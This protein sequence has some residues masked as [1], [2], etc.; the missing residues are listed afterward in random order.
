MAQN[1]N[2]K[3]SIG[4]LMQ[5][6]YGKLIAFLYKTT[7]SFKM[8]WKGKHNCNSNKGQGLYEEFKNIVEGHNS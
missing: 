6:E 5:K 4:L 8:Q 1:T 2:S 3:N 7:R